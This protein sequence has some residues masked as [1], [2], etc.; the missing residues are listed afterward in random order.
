MKTDDH[1]PY[2][3]PREASPPRHAGTK[4]VHGH[5]EYVYLVS[6]FAPLPLMVIR[7][8]LGGGAAAAGLLYLAILLL[9]AGA[10]LLWILFQRAQK[11]A[12]K[13]ARREDASL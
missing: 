5:L 10:Y 12:R 8:A 6:L 13:A 9:G 11:K 3:A 7:S 4:I 1:N 2:V